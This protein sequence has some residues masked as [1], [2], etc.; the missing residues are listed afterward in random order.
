M[1][2]TDVH[3][4]YGFVLGKLLF[5]HHS[6]RP[7][8]LLSIPASFP[9]ALAEALREQQLMRASL[10]RFVIAGVAL[11]NLPDVDVLF[12]FVLRNW[13]KHHRGPTHSLA[14]LVVSSLCVTAPLSFWLRTSRT[15]ALLFALLCGGSH[16][17]SDYV[18][19]AGLQ[20]YWPLA[21]RSGK[22]ALG[23]VTVL[24]AILSL[25]TCGLFVV[26]RNSRRMLLVLTAYVAVVT[27]YLRWKMRLLH[28]AR[29]YFESKHRLSEDA[30]FV[31]P[32]ALFPRTFSLVRSSD[33]AV[34]ETVSIAAMTEKKEFVPVA[35]P[36]ISNSVAVRK[37]FWRNRWVLLDAVG[38][39]SLTALF[40]S[41]QAYSWYK[42]RQKMK[43]GGK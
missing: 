17:L 28:V 11:A 7:D 29:G 39:L 23:C 16:L 19:N 10:Q 3:S 22:Q 40:W 15:K 35:H 6:R 37:M 24:D 41:W 12:A 13:T 18:G 32:W 2:L 26:S 31:H 8:M 43:F 21:G 4:V 42:N 1:G 36:N 14:F 20:I 38:S 25:L 30:G 9:P 27:L 5:E 34:I 33:G